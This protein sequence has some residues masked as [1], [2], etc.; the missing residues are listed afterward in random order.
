GVLSRMALNEMGGSM[1]LF[2]AESGKV[3]EALDTNLE[4]P[5][6]QSAGRFAD[7]EELRA[8]LRQ[9]PDTAYHLDPV[10]G[11]ARL[12]EGPP[13]PDPGPGVG[14]AEGGPAGPRRGR[15]LRRSKVCPAARSR[16]RPQKPLHGMTAGPFR[17]GGK[18]PPRVHVQG[19]TWRRE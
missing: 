14:R 18:A 1:I 7:S 2:L 12:H 4:A 3:Y 8:F 10:P 19:P 5:T 13:D 17:T 6:G 15:F 11:W 16:R 9:H